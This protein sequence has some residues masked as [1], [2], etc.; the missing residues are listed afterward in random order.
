MSWNPETR[1]PHCKPIGSHRS[2]ITEPLRV[3]IAFAEN[4]PY[5]D[6]SAAEECDINHI[7]ARY[8]ATGELPHLNAMEPNFLDASEMDFHEH[9]NIIRRAQE[10]FE[11]IPA[12]IRDRFANSPG[13]FL[14]FVQDPANRKELAE[15][16]LLTPELT[17]SILSPQSPAVEPT[18]VDS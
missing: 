13:N 17:Q 4:S 9:M 8:L 16:G 1:T 3:S 14:D 10:T 2:A 6:Q 18:D 12:K 11:A 15:M 7:M 5:T